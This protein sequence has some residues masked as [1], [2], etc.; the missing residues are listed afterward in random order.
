MRAQ[1]RAE[2]RNDVIWSALPQ[3]TSTIAQS[4]NACRRAD[5]DSSMRNLLRGLVQR[6]GP[7]VIV[8][9][10]IGF[11]ATSIQHRRVLEPVMST[12]EQ[13]TGT[14]R[15]CVR[16]PALSSAAVATAVRLSRSCWE[17]VEDAVGQINYEAGRLCRSIL[18]QGSIM[19]LRSERLTS[20][21]TGLRGLVVATQ[22]NTTERVYL[23]A[24]KSSSD[25]RTIYIPHAPVSNSILYEDLPTDVAIL[26][27][28]AEVEHYR[29]LGV[30]APIEIGGD[31]SIPYTDLPRPSQSGSVLYAPSPHSKEQIKDQVELLVAGGVASCEV[32]LHPRMNA[33]VVGDVLPRSWTIVSGGSTWAR[34]A[35]GGASAVIQCNSGVGLEVLR[36]GLRLVDLRA[37]GDQPSYPYLTSDIVMPIQ[38]SLQ[39][40]KTLSDNPW[41]EAQRDT[42]VSF[43]RTWSEWTGRDAARRIVGAMLASRESR[44]P[45]RVLLD[46]WARA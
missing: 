1:L 26:R 25:C 11:L 30:G 34:M 2:A 21:A 14:I 41:D 19:H 31:P 35:K 13:E 16:A 38:D 10:D 44:V 46:G 29:R 18:L 22:H 39:L 45:S 15:R 8:V 37:E 20:I 43:A 40:Q 23:N 17:Q 36:C 33:D 32:V 4:P 5:S 27:G 42:A 24:F 9:G 3:L 28:A 6:L 12:L 7:E